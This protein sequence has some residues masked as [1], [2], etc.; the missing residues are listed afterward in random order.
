MHNHWASEVPQATIPP[1]LLLSSSCPDIVVHSSQAHSIK[2]A[3]L[4]STCP[5]DSVHHLESAWNSKKS[6]VEYL[7]MLPELDR[8]NIPNY[9]ETIEISSFGHYQPASIGNL[10]QFFQPVHYCIQI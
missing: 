3:L 5:L 9:F 7:Q 8:L 10:H 4:E 1:L 6:K 2:I